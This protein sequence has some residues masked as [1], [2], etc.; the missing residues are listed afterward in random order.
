MI[1]SLLIRPFLAGD[2]LQGLVNRKI[3][4]SIRSSVLAQSAP[5]E[6]CS[7]RCRPVRMRNC[8]GERYSTNSGPVVISQ[9][10]GRSV[11]RYLPA[12]T[13]APGFVRS[14]GRS[15]YSPALSRPNERPSRS[16]SSNS[17]GP[18]LKSSC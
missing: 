7:V 3:S 17:F 13:A 16:A 11:A 12:A 2:F 15:R 8:P 9:N 5:L 10:H 6:K 18:F 1:L 4:T 14:A